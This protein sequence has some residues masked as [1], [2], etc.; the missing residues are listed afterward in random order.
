MVFITEVQLD[1]HTKVYHE[2]IVELKNPNSLSVVAEADNN[3]RNFYF[4]MSELSRA[5]ARFHRNLTPSCLDFH[6]ISKLSCL[7]CQILKSSHRRLKVATFVF[8]KL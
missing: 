5:I 3:F 8:K 6:V 7:S 2:S 4:K 1:L